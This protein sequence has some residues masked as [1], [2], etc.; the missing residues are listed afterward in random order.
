M[1]PQQFESA[2]VCLCVNVVTDFDK[3][4]NFIYE[5]FLKTFSKVYNE[6][7]PAVCVMA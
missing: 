6:A 7:P 1:N 2:I 4:A 5:T 3:D